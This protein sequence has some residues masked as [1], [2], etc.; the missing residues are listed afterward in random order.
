MRNSKL[1]AV[2]RTFDGKRMKAFHDFLKSPYFNKR[3]ELVRL[4]EIIEK[5]KKTERKAI[6]SAVCTNEVYNEQRL[7]HLISDLFQLVER[8]LLVEFGNEDSFELDCKLLNYYLDKNLIKHYNYGFSKMA[9]QLDQASNLDDTKFRK[10]LALAEI[11]DQHFHL[12]KTRRYDPSLQNAADAL[13]RY[14]IIKKLKYC[15]A[16]LDRQEVLAMDYA[17]NFQDEV[18]NYISKNEDFLQI[19]IIKAYYLRLQLVDD[20]KDAY[21]Y[22]KQYK[23]LVFQD[24]DNVQDD[25]QQN[26]YYLGINYCLMRIR[27][28]YK[29]YAN[30]LME[31][32][33][34]GV[35]KGILLDNGKISPWTFKNMVKLGL[36]L[37][38]FEWTKNFIQNYASLLDKKYKEDAVNYNM[39]ELF[40]YQRNYGEAFS[41]LNEARFTDI[42]YA[43]DSKVMLVKIFV[44]TEEDSALDSLL[45]SFSTY[46]QRKREIT[47]DVKLPYQNFVKGVTLFR[48]YKGINK[49][50]PVKQFLENT[51]V[52]TAKSWLLK[53]VNAR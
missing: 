42:Y 26:L 23:D 6:Y 21:R 34:K 10:E 4:F 20:N 5:G 33:E 25:E 45:N 11:A 16:M 3:G 51:K 2:L 32:Y 29:N 43:L 48:R 31:F 24:L 40:Y 38:R 13:D 19:P 47:K 7:N 17:I 53:Q 22:F 36:G 12:Q 27:K 28:G 37:N 8:F 44:E 50:Q 49:M 30:D 35:E 18:L 15:C 41:Y 52:I 1:F 46:L 14:F 39:A 9:K